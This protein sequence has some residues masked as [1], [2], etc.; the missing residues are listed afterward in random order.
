MHPVFKGPFTTYTFNHFTVW[1]VVYNAGFIE[2][3][4]WHNLSEDFIRS[5]ARA[6]NVMVSHTTGLGSRI[7]GYSTLSTEHL[8]DYH[9]NSITKV[10]AR[11]YVWKVGEGFP[12]LIWPKTLK[13]VAVSIPMSMD[14]T[15]I[16]STTT[17]RP[18]VC[19]LWRGGMSC[20]VSVALHFCIAAHRSKYHCYKQ[21]PSR[22][23]LRCSKATS[24][25]NKQTNN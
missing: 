6:D 4:T 25:P 9:Y 1:D 11:W 19:I 7:G 21:A 15:S 14:H 22:Y 23:D 17:G 2:H 24:N 12:D 18:R 20:P 5:C 13:W 3:Q 10:S 8:T 16:D